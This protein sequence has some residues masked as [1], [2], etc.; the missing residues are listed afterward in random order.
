MTEKECRGLRG[1]W[2]DGKCFIVTRVKAK[3][4]LVR[5]V[6]CDPTELSIRKKPPIAVRRALA[7]NSV[8]RKR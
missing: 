7:R 4:T 2:I 5:G 8:K 3:V 1:D 6:G